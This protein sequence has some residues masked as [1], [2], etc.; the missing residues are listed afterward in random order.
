MGL[1]M[2][3]PCYFVL[4]GAFMS[5]QQELLPKAAVTTPDWLVAVALRSVLLRW[6]LPLLN[7]YSNLIR[8][9]H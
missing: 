2:E 4:K 8:I 6:M 3:L 5:T 9:N 7:L 1:L